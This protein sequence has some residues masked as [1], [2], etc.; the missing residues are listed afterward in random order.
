MLHGLRLKGFVEADA[1]GEALGIGEHEVRG[2]LEAF[3]VASTAVKAPAETKAAEG[4]PRVTVEEPKLPAGIEFARYAMCLM[5]AKG[6]TTQAVEIARKRYPSQGRIH[7][8][9][10]AAVNAGTTTDPTWAG[11]LVDYQLFA[12]DFV[13]RRDQRVEHPRNAET[14]RDA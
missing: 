5:A 2:R 8:V 3:E 6:N 12:G 1:L 10:K 4:A 14:P 11:A 7:S 9:L 13:D